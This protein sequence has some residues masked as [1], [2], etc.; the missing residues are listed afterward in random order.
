MY[1]SP[2]EDKIV[3]PPPPSKNQVKEEIYRTLSQKMIHPLATVEK[4]VAI[5]SGTRIWQF[6]IILGGA[7]LGSN[8]NICSHCLIE[9]NVTIG[10]RVTVKSGVQ[11]WNGISLEDD[12]FIGP[13]ATFANDLYPRSRKYK[14]VIPKTIVERGASIG[15]N[16]TILP[17]VTIGKYAMVGAGAVVTKDVPAHSIVYGN[18]AKPKGW[19]CTC[20]N[21][22]ECNSKVNAVKCICKRH[23]LITACGGLETADKNKMNNRGAKS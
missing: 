7:S 12:T 4:G 11:L 14:T 10:S 9:G 3:S 13:N 6:V 16:A 2:D 23:Y 19:I 20:G 8:C 21:K 22:I 15:A 18:P 17:G 1:R 5:G